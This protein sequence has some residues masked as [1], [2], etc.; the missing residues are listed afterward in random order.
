MQAYKRTAFS[1]MAIV[2]AT[3]VVATIVEK[4]SSS[5]Y[6]SD[7]IYGSWWFVGLWAAFAVVSIAYIIRR[8]SRLSPSVLLLHFSFAVILLGALTTYI[9][10]ERGTVHLRTGENVSVYMN[11]DGAVC[12][13]PFTLQLLDFSVV[14]YPGT[15]SP[16]DYSSHIMVHDETPDTIR[17]S[18]NNIAEV[19]HYRLY[20]SAY[21]EDGE[22][23]YLGLSHDPWGIGITYFGYAMLFCS[24][25]LS[26]FSKR[27][28]IRALYRKASLAAVATVL[29]LTVSAT[30]QAQARPK[31]AEQSIA[32]SIGK[33]YVLYNNRICPFNTLATDFLTKLSGKPTWHGYSA[34]E[35]LT[36]WMFYFDDWE[37][38][39]LIRIK[40][41]YTQQLLGI[42]TQWASFSDFWDE[43]NEYKLSEPLAQA[44]SSSESAQQL[45]A[46]READEK[47]N[48]I[49]MFYSGELIKLFP[50]PTADGKLLWLAPGSLHIPTDMPQEEWFFIRKTFDYI[51]EDIV[52]G[53]N[54]AA[55]QLISGI[56]KYQKK[57]GG[58]ILPSERKIQAELFYNTLSSVRLPIYLTLLMG[59]LFW[60][61]FTIGIFKHKTVMPTAIITIYNVLIFLYLTSLLL[62]RWYISAH[63]PL[64]NGYETMQFMAWSVLLLT[65][66]M[67]RTFPLL[68]S[69]S[70][71]LTG[72][73]MLVSM[74]SNS[75]PQV[76]SLMPVL[77]SPLLSIHV[78]SV[79]LSYTLFAMTTLL[80]ITYF[81]V[82]HYKHESTP[83]YLQ[84]LQ[85]I[86]ALSRLL[87]Y[88]AEYTLILGI[89]I[90]AVWAN[91]SWGRYWGWD[92]KEVWA[93]VTMLIY[94]VPLHVE[95]IRTL[96]SPRN[97]HIY[98]LLAFL[99]IL[100]TYFGVNYLLG[101]M[102]SYAGN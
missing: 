13:L 12:S 24:L 81:I 55:H 44:Y 87:L 17:I 8:H 46:L 5:Q 52:L 101:G 83:T 62:L 40:D 51:T 28:K 85:R 65:L 80:A 99:S 54:N 14:T 77:Q 11:T 68:I 61:T 22:G 78:M 71:L 89:F 39:R 74:L 92:P 48:L 21:D 1:L 53:N 49:R 31:V 35:V 88:P 45:K 20:Q 90:G 100:M 98:M 33:L 41:T 93:L 96:Q 84:S 38:A 25:L 34:N 60:I 30:A 32:D 7:H 9:T 102:H 67:Q 2:T 79:M 15:D 36:G 86:T 10:A 56:Y 29:M 70:T 66:L 16:M 6:V 18:M 75:N 69:F 27:T 3:L 50:Y 73:I 23:T 19:R 58:D 95:S 94:A 97:Y 43:Y 91:Q 42:D 47:F 4:Y 76:T 59:I 72:L 57:R 63:V 82:R 64:S 26:L 37:E